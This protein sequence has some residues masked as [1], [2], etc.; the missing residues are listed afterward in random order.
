MWAT[1]QRGRFADYPRRLIELISFQSY[2]ALRAEREQTFLG[3]FWWF[4]EPIVTMA[5]FYFVFSH[6]LDR[7]TENYVAFLLTGLVL[8]KWFGTAFVSGGNAIIANA[9]LLRR[10][11]VP[12]F[13]LPLISIATDT[14]KFAVALVLLLAFLWIYGYEIHGSYVAIPA[15]IGTQLLLICGSAIFLCSVTPFL[16]DINLVLDNLLRALFFVSGIFFPL[17]VVP[18]EIR[19]Y[20]MLNPMAILIEAFR[21]VVLESQ[22][23]DWWAL[24]AVCGASV[25]LGFVGLTILKRKDQDYEKYL[26]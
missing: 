12:K 23:P 16:P 21:Q 17:S 6:V 5:I 24:A 3:F 8:W 7:G 25:F 18:D 11:Y 22:W 13:V 2:A 1:G 20:L 4:V 14:F 26:S 15:I 19:K 10:V 9:G